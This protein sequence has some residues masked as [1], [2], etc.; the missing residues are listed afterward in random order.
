VIKNQNTTNTTNMPDMKKDNQN[1][2]IAVSATNLTPNAVMKKNETL[3]RNGHLKSDFLRAA[4]NTKNNL[5]YMT[6]TK[7]TASPMINNNLSL[8]TSNTNNMISNNKINSLNKSPSSQN[9]KQQI[10]SNIQGLNT[11]IPFNINLSNNNSRNLN[12]NEISTLSDLTSSINRDRAAS[13]D[14]IRK[15]T[16]VIVKPK[17]NISFVNNINNLM[18]SIES[19]N[20]HLGSRDYPIN[21]YQNIINNVFPRGSSVNNN[22]NKK[23]RNE[24]V[25]SF[26]SKNSNS[27]NVSRDKKL[28]NYRTM[29]TGVYK[30]YKEYKEYRENRNKEIKNVKT[31]YSVNLDSFSKDKDRDNSTGPAINHNNKSMLT[32]NSSML[33]LDKKTKHSRNSTSISNQFLLPEYSFNNSTTLGKVNQNASQVKLKPNITMSKEPTNYFNN[34]SSSNYLYLKQRISNLKLGVGKFKPTSANNGKRSI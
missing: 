31:N 5:S 13:K 17:I 34:L 11:H 15:T 2:Q 26:L 10:I 18:T 19:F 20:Q 29:M 4:N 33:Y 28:P 6:K 8:N 22:S 24:K 1:Y 3:S 9:N 32:G 30:D 12:K 21:N 23:S 16:N 25:D 7:M 14:S 27:N